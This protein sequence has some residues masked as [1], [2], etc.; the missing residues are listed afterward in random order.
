MHHNLLNQDDTY[1]FGECLW[2]RTE[3]ESG[4]PSDTY[5]FKSAFLQLPHPPEFDPKILLKKYLL[6]KEIPLVFIKNI[7]PDGLSS[8]SFS[9][10]D[11]FNIF[12]NEWIESSVL[13]TNKI[14]SNYERIDWTSHEVYIFLEKLFVWWKSQREHFRSRT[15]VDGVF[16]NPRGNLVK[17]VSVLGQVLLHRT[18]K[19]HISENTMQLIQ[20]LRDISTDAVYFFPMCIHNKLMNEQEVYGQLLRAVNSSKENEANSAVAGLFIWYMASIRRRI[21]FPNKPVFEC[22]V[23]IVYHKYNTGLSRS[24]KELAHVVDEVPEL[25]DPESLSRLLAGLHNLL[26]HTEL[27]PNNNSHIG[28]DIEIEDLPEMRSAA[29]QLASALYKRYQIYEEE[30]PEV[31]VSWKLACVSDSLPEVR[32]M[33]SELS[34]EDI[35]NIRSNLDNIEP[36]VIKNNVRRCIRRNKQKKFIKRRKKLRRGLYQDGL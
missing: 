33:W 19:N 1:K 6:N 36:I 21:P 20:D 10:G 8:T 15:M 35:T 14:M 32:N 31:L 27:R 4:L 34:K 30:M 7:S 11:E 24:L 13:A 28:S 18:T 25:I 5:F 16:G 3:D 26:Y 23:D 29:A 9:G 17:L 2:R 12:M 22:L